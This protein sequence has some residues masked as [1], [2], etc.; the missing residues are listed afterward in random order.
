MKIFVVNELNEIDINYNTCHKAFK[1]LED[2]INYAEEKYKSAI[3]DFGGEE[4]CGIN[5]ICEDGMD[6]QICCDDH[7][8]EI[9]IDE[10][11]LI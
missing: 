2:A 3:D 10:I 5:S 9:H 7:N 11:D 4:Y 1:N 8:V 6:Y